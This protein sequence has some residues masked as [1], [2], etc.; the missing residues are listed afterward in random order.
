MMSRV[1]MK[2]NEVIAEAALKAGCR[3]FFGYPITPQSGIPEYM[4]VHLPE[5]GGCFLQAESELAAINMVM[6]CAASGKQV[7]TSSSGPGISL[8]SEGFSFLAACEVPAVIVDVMRG[9]PGLGSLLSTQG[10]YFQVT[11]G[12]GHG[13]YHLIVLAPATLQEA[14]NMIQSAWDLAFRYRNPVMVLADAFMAQTMESVEIPERKA[15]LGDVST[16]ALGK[17]P[18]RT[19]KRSV[20]KSICLNASQMEKLNSR[21]QAKYRIMQKEAAA[22]TVEMGNAR[23]AIA[24]FGT[25]GRISKTAVIKLRDKG[26]RVG[27]IRPKT[28]YPFP[29]QA[30][31]ELPDSVRYILSVEMNSGQM[32]R[33][34]R[35]IAGKGVQVNHMG[36]AG[37]TIPSSGE[38]ASRCMEILDEMGGG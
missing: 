4:S 26:Y 32:V 14:V 15:D 12:G 8:M 28:L 38:I 25:P 1:L 19:G 20:L 9:G 33:D 29:V 36:H 16:W 23:L 7:M 34:I 18:E 11:C 13:D 3:Y 2:G 22:E 35:A 10:D 27:L 30:F 24:A 5:R 37:C 6:G 31:S 21:L 17:R